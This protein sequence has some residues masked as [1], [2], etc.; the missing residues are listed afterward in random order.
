MCRKL[1]YGL[2]LIAPS[3]LAA[4]GQLSVAE[5]TYLSTSGQVAIHVID[6]D[7]DS[8]GDLD[9]LQAKIYLT[10]SAPK[11]L[12]GGNGQSRIASLSLTSPNG[13]FLLANHLE[14][15]KQIELNQ[16]NLNLD[17]YNLQLPTREG[18]IIG[19]SNSNRIYSQ[20]GG[21]I[22]KLID[23]TAPQKV[24]PGNMGLRISSNDNL[25]LTEIHRSHETISL[26]TGESISKSFEIFPE[27][28]P[29]SELYVKLSYFNADGADISSDKEEIWKLNENG[30]WKNLKTT[31]SRFGTDELN[32]AEAYD[33]K[34]SLTYTIG[35]EK[36]YAVDVSSIP[37]AFTPN[38][39]RV[40]DTFVIPF[41]DEEFKGTVTILSRWGDILYSTDDYYQKPW[42]GT[43]KG[44]ALPVA[45]YYY[46]LRFSE[47]ADREIKGNISI[48]R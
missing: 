21:K 23:L 3:T 36:E 32:T 25:G 41:I 24:A 46:V 43:H 35:P 39:D 44:K 20:R 31:I 5:N 6:S 12:I 22:I 10:S 7:L 48:V 45:T 33:R 8:N 38:N 11:A 2:F 18:T 17:Q 40:N 19:E 16:A 1:I 34:P 42:D 29:N 37:T 28:A 13:E 4:Q 47:K 9:G 15:D 14:V 30:D 27:F 26:P